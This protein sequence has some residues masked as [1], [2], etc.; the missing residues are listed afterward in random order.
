MFESNTAP[1]ISVNGR[2]MD[3]RK[4]REDLHV[5][6][7]QFSEIVGIPQYRLSGI[8]LKKDIPSEGEIVKIAVV[9]EKIVKGEIKLRKKK[10]ISKEIFHSSIVAM[11][12]RRGY[13]RT[14]R[15]ADYLGLLN[16]LQ[17]RF[18]ANDRKGPKAI[19]FFAGCGGLCYGITAAGFNI[20]ASN[21]LR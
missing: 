6:Q 3:V 14:V 10:R 8:E 19:S 11:N 18:E 12:P 15:N 2:G 1:S 4:M 20:V 21:E 13:E 5:S 7:A 9:A 16:E 17:A